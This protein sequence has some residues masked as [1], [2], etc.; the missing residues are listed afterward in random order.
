MYRVGKSLNRRSFLAIAT[1]T[2]L[3]PALHHSA[4]SQGH[5]TSEQRSVLKPDRLQPG[6]AVGII[7]PAG[8]TFLQEDLEIVI[9]AVRGLG[10]VPQVAPHVLSRYGYLAGRDSERA[11]DVNQF[12]ADPTIAALLPIQ[13]GWGSSRIL[14]YLDYDVIRQNPKI[15]VGFSDL[16]ALLLGIHAQTGLVTF[17]GPNGLTAWRSPQT[18]S[19]RQVLFDGGMSM[20][21][22]E[23]SPEDSDRLMQVRH[24]VRTITP[25]RAEGPLIG[26]NLS[27]LSGIVGSPY[28][29]N[30]DGAILFLE[31]IGENIYRLDRMI[32]H[33]KLAGVLDHLAGFIFGQCSHCGPDPDYGSLTLEQVLQDHIQPLGIPAWS[34]AAIGHVE[35]VLTLPMGTAV[36]M[37]AIAGSIQMLEAAVN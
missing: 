21:Q 31:D 8:A 30:L 15:I 35:P 10:L 12:F 28:L 29:P 27:V 1:T 23:W 11:D 20:M 9:D 16:T 7:S 37:D 32:T 33:L 3:L 19:F 14:P 36:A 18:T 5:Q 4:A 2:A 24:R 25:G 6:Q 17:H 13:G 22:S 34:G 26:G